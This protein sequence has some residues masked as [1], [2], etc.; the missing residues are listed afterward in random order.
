MG[1]IL[2]LLI[3]T[4]AHIRALRRRRRLK[5]KV[6]RRGID[7]P[8][9][10]ETGVPLVSR[11]LPVTLESRV[12][13]GEPAPDACFGTG[14]A[15]VDVVIQSDGRGLVISRTGLADRHQTLASGIDDVVLEYVVPHVELH[16]KLTRTRSRRIVSVERVV[17]HGA[18]FGAA[19]L[20]AIAANRDGC[21]IA[22][23]D[24]VIARDDVIYACN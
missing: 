14:G 16:L 3:A 12:V 1:P 9:I 24:D 13:G 18:L 22:R 6:A 23:V 7:E 21:G 10:G 20:R 17:D 19:A 8:R 11:S 4:G 2:A 5:V 15:I